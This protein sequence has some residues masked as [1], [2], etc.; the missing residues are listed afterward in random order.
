MKVMTK[1]I[2][3]TAA[4]VFLFA[5]AATFIFTAPTASA[6]EDERKS[7]VHADIST[8]EKNFDL[9]VA[10]K[11]EVIDKIETTISILT[12]NDMSDLEK[13]YRLA[14]WA[15]DRVT[16]DNDFWSGGYNFKYYRH[17]WDAYGALFDKS[18]CAG[19]SILYANLCHAADLPCKFVRT[20]PK[21]LDHTINYIPDINGNA[22]YVDVT[23]N[24]FIL[25]EKAN[26]FAPMI[27]KEFA[28]IQKD[29]TDGTFEYRYTV[30]G[31]DDIADTESDDKKKEED[32]P[33][34]KKDYIKDDEVEEYESRS[35]TRIKD[36][37]ETT[38][39]QWFKTYALH[40]DTSLDF[41][42]PYVELGSGTRGVH[43]ASYKDFPKQFSATEKP[44]LWFLE[45]FYKDPKDIRSKIEN[46]VIDKQIMEVSLPDSKVDCSSVKEIEEYLSWALGVGMFPSLD[47]NNQ[48]VT[49]ESYLTYNT[50]YTFTLDSYNE[51]T[52]KTT[53]T[54]KGLGDY[55]GEFKTSVKVIKK[56][57]NPMKLKAKDTTLKYKKLKNKALT[58]KRS[59]VIGISGAKGS[60]NF[61]LAS[62]KKNK[63]SFKK[64]FSI[65][66]N[67]GDI[68]VKKGVKKGTYKV[69]VKIKDYGDSDYAESA[70][71]SVTIKV[72]VK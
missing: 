57:A 49:N 34:S 17:Q 63:K 36:C 5:I 53:L 45:D 3:K 64:Y 62:A 21:Q 9:T 39:D 58:I 27:D 71:K 19:I 26:S 20:D 24:D 40:Q 32:D 46:R 61:E 23:E 54:I 11:M 60:L 4:I 16:Y 33:E 50:D 41:C 18:V 48:I 15:N 31:V 7:G 65:E 38:Y 55:S 30:P 12:D 44:G 28:F 43:R 42:D 68:T 29:C 47:E 35:G 2:K 70:W 25:S 72:V 66:P 22:Y 56:L 69:K 8:F 6:E 10:Q 13:Y 37:F 51:K 1:L 67:V 59:E 52:G 14:L